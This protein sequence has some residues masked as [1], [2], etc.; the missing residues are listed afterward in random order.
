[1]KRMSFVAV[2]VGLALASP[3]F[4]GETK[5]TQDAV[6]IG[7]AV[8]VKKPVDVARLA[9]NP[10]RYVGKTVRLEGTVKE[11]C[12]GAGCWVQ[13]A[14]PGGVS[15]LAKSL[16]ESVLLPIDCAGRKI[17]VQGVV[18]EQAARDAEAHKVHDCEA[19]G[20]ACPSPTF[21]VS[22][23]GIQLYPGKP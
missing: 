17:V 13:V 11:V 5:G 18:T 19:E 6:S 8:T 15:F 2:V 14:N 3:A 1:M 21:L 10:K 20:H 9:K 23:Q 16:D 7:A 12:Q 22:T 4:P